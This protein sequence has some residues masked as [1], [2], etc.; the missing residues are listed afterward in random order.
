MMMKMSWEKARPAEGPKP[1][2]SVK[3]HSAMNR[4]DETGTPGRRRCVPH[5][6]RT[7]HRRSTV[8]SAAPHLAESRHSH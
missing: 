4:R 1:A 6:A 5:E 8:N 3:P 2:E 7:T